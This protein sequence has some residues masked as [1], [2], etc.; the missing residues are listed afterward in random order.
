M[1]HL[2]QQINDF[3]IHFNSKRCD[4]ECKS[5][6]VFKSQSHISIPKGAIMSDGEKCIKKA[7]NIFQ[8][9]KVRLWD[10]IYSEEERSKLI[11]IPKGAIM[12]IGQTLLF[13]SYPYISIP[14]GAIMRSYSPIVLSL[15]TNFNSKR[16]DYESP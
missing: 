1:R 9:Q 8:F 16:C 11:S 4:Y 2:Q 12:R 3:S 5:S 6:N 7:W 15:H 14:K 13:F 10:H